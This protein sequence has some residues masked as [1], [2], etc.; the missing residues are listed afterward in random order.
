MVRRFL[1]SLLVLY[2]SLM[3]TLIWKFDYI[4]SKALDYLDSFAGITEENFLHSLSQVH[5]LSSV[6]IDEFHLPTLPKPPNSFRGI[7]MKSSSLK[8]W[9]TICS[10]D[11]IK[12]VFCVT[13][14][15]IIE[16]I[17]CVLCLLTVFMPSTRDGKFRSTVNLLCKYLGD[18]MIASYLDVIQESGYNGAY[19][20]EIEVHTY[21]TFSD[22]DRD[23]LIDLLSLI[24]ASS[25]LSFCC[26]KISSISYTY[27]L[28]HLYHLYTRV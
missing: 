25:V 5:G 3:H 24:G 28:S 20:K 2:C 19:V 9:L 21:I 23:N 22:S 15:I 10:D 17:F 13:A 8:R 26:T 14:S 11:S 12:C 27:I 7:R 4:Y 6:D 1:L 16:I 18:F